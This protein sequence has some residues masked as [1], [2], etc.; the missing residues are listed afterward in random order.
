MALVIVVT[1]YSPS[2][3]KFRQQWSQSK[4][5]LLDLEKKKKEINRARTY[6]RV[7]CREAICARSV[8]RVRWHL[9]TLPGP[10][11]TCDPAIPG[12]MNSS[13]LTDA[14][15]DTDRFSIE[16]RSKTYVLEP[17]VGRENLIL[18]ILQIFNYHFVTLKI[19]LPNFT[20]LVY[21]YCYY[22]KRKRPRTRS[23]SWDR[24]SPSLTTTVSLLF[25]TGRISRL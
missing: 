13:R 15:P 17:N 12:Q 8:R 2:A 1:P 16:S 5:I 25:E 22:D 6:C 18:Q 10:T 23:I 14:S 21:Y 9:R 3:L 19:F 11:E 4:R 20:Q 7:R 24:R